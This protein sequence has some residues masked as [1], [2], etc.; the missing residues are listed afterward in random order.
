MQSPISSRRRIP[1]LV[2]DIMSKPPAVI[3]ESGLLVEAA[4]IMHE[5]EIGSVIVVDKGGRVRGIVTERDV[6]A[7]IAHGFDP[8]STRVWEVMT[9]NPAIIRENERVSAALERISESGV[10]H[11][12][13]VDENGRPVGVVS[14][15]DIANLILV[16]MDMGVI[17]P[18]V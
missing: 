8:K 7:A 16:L 5:R 2:S 13:V 3:P 4:K 1:L 18:S 14:F 6:V 9:E 17:H 10:R 12:P 11:L 15:R